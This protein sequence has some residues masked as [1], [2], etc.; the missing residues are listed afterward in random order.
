M[1]TVWLLPP[2][3]KGTPVEVEATPDILTPMLVAGYSQCAPPANPQEVTN[4]V[5]D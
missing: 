5:D 1:S 3:G 4:H 2:W